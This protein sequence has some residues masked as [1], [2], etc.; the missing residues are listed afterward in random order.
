MAVEDLTGRR[1]GR[2]V[3]LRK[4]EGSGKARYLVRC[5]CG[6]EK[7]VLADNLKRGMTK[8]CGV[9][10]RGGKAWSEKRIKDLTGKRFGQMIVLKELGNRK[11][12][13]KCD[14]GKE[15][16]VNK[17]HLVHGEIQSC[18]CLLQKQAYQNQKKY[19]YEG[20]YIAVIK[21]TKATSRSKSGVRGVCWDRTKEKWRANICFKGERQEL[22]YFNDIKDAIKARR[23]A[24]D[25]LYKPAIESFEEGKEN[26]EN[27]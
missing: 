22:G 20:T 4:E 17:S 7:V 8:S 14:C 13:C 15:K 6:R 11:V 9:C 21:N 1:F 26:G 16:V 23:D 27:D 10:C 18:G 12:L 25:K 19:Y 3:V 2:L 24:E 5:D